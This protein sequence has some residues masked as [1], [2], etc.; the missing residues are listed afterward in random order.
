M[1]RYTT[2]IA[3]T[4]CL[5][6]LLLFFIGGNLFSQ[7]PDTMWTKTYGGAEDDGITDMKE[8]GDDGYILTGWI[9]SMGAG[10]YDVWL[11]KIDANGDTLWTKTFGGTGDDWSDTVQPTSDGGYIVCG[12]TESFGAGEGDVW[13]IK[14][15]ANGDTLWT[16][17]YGGP[18]TDT[19]ISV[20]QTAD[21]G[22]FIG[23]VT[24]SYG[25][26]EEDIWLL[27]TGANG[28]TLWTK[29]YGGTEHD[30]YAEGA[31]W[32]Y[33]VKG[34]Q[35]SDGGYIVAA[36]T[37][38]FGGADYDVW[39][40]KMDAAGDTLW[41]KTYGGD[42]NER[43][44][45]EVQ[46][47]P[48]SGY[49][50]VGSTSSFGPQSPW[51]FYPNVYLIK[52]D[53][54]GD[55]LW[56]KAYGGEDWDKGFSFLQTN[57]GGYLIAGW[58]ESFGAGKIDAY[59]L[60]TDSSGDTLWTKTVGGNENDFAYAVLQSG[61]DGYLVV[62]NTHSFSSGDSDCWLIRLGPEQST[63]I[64]KIDITQAPNSFKLLQNF[65][66]P[67]NPSTTIEFSMPKA[68]FVS[69]KIYNLLGQEVST[70]VSQKLNAG[71]YTYQVKGENLTSSVYYYKLV[72]GD[73]VEVKKMI[74]I[75]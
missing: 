46:Q 59:L 71:M 7:A 23:A 49:F 58:T 75:K 16:K 39:L 10:G 67:F 5:V 1:K 64:E 28:D 74:L 73:Y 9:Q 42:L 44:Y 26:G 38:S 6:Q 65:P 12:Y 53:S 27:K 66:N 22:Y 14:T 4:F 30:G 62:G 19:G 56:T 31:S 3:R 35:T 60:K 61:E 51:S 50:I 32:G 54:F 55:T 40:L 33:C 69:L 63:N 8:T 68:A 72:A 41:T 20:Q 43:G 57:D 48:D 17:T 13:L 15:D 70:L 11:I 36:Y 2:K 47:S 21:G 24:A 25:S 37:N 34:R 45:L 18:Q 29:T 52:T